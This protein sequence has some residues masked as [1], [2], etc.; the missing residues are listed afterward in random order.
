VRSF[1]A[2]LA[3]RVGLGALGLFLV[4][5]VATVL[6]LRSLLRQQLDATLLRIAE[7]EAQAGAAATSSD[8]AFHEGVLLGDREA[9]VP[10]L[11]RYAQLWS[12][13]GRPLIRSRNLGR[14][15]EVPPAA[16]AL[17]QAGQVAWSSHRLAD[18]RSIRSLVYPLRLVGETHGDHL[19]QVAA[20]TAPI[21]QTLQ[22]F[23]LLV[24]LLA[25]LL[26]VGAYAIGWRIAE[27]ALRPTREIA[28]QA[29]SL[30]AGALDA[31]I[32]AHADVAEFQ[33]LVSVLNAMLGRLDTAFQGQRRFT[34]DASH[35]LRGPLNVL[36]GE[37]DV[38]LKRPRT[39]AEYREVLTRCREEVLRLVRLANDL[40]LLARADAG[41]SA[42]RI[43]TLD[44]YEMAH[45][46]LERYRPLAAERGL[47]IRLEGVAAVVRGD[48]ELLERAIA[49]LVDNAVKYAAAPGTIEIWVADTSQPS[50]TIRDSGPGV[51]DHLV[52]LLFQRFLRG[53]PARRRADGAGLGLS[54]AQ[55]A[56]QGLGGTLEFLGNS[57]GAAFRLCLP[58]APLVRPATSDLRRP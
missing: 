29:E 26:T 45:S 54:I 25:L 48:G 49:N 8:F 28:E 6:S 51:P 11:T 57:P 39:E 10:E 21:T 40:L 1:R 44:I 47:A 13:D 3:L 56:A 38:A 34:A 41:S 14:D 24:V 55:A 18:G 15:L 58:P 35:E 17:A 37:L 31:R 5:A 43:E 42:D 52:P 36:R 32:T 30:E 7:T 19:L 9:A 50:V 2:A 23:A 33:R 53:D 16:L 46:V 20:P 4:L 22:R 27:T 12:S